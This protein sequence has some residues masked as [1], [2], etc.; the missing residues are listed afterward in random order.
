M[1]CWELQGGFGLDH[2]VMTHRPAPVPGP[3]E[4]SLQVMAVSLNYR[5][6]LM[7]RGHYD[8]R[9]PLPLVPCSDAVGVV[10]AVGEGVARLTP[11]DRVC[12]IFSQGWLTGPPH[13]GM[14]GTTLGGP[15]DGT[16]AEHLVVPAEATVHVPPHLTDEEAACLPCAGVTAWRALVTESGVGEGSTV[17]TLGTG[18][19]SLFAVQIGRMRGAEV[20]VTSS[21]DTKLA[22]AATL[23]ATDGLNYKALPNWGAEVQARTN[24]RGVDVVVELGGAGTL[25]QSLK[26]VK[27]GGTI[28]LIGVLDGVSTE[29]ALTSILMRGIRVQ[30]IFVGNRDDFE[31]LNRALAAHTKVRPVVHQV[32]RFEDVPTALEDLGRGQHV[33]K[34]VIRVAAVPS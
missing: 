16:L 23:G 4:V 27:V 2:L 29:V 22:R 11:G 26:A 14:L 32:Y 8:P 25:K 13:R 34:L 7:V 12:P 28:A 31:G 17:L 3:G 10:T 5:D 19:V 15:L 24:G 30:G 20:I 9:Q 18:G 6:L 1:R 21:S 33:G